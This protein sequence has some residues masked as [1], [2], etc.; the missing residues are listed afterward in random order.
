[1]VVP[2]VE[3]IVTD[4]VLGGPAVPVGL[5]EARRTQEQM[6]TLAMS[7]DVKTGTHQLRTEPTE[8]SPRFRGRRG[9]YPGDTSW[10]RL[11]TVSSSRHIVCQRCK[12]GI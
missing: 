4:K 3:A 12:K 11:G 7:R 10:H 6:I 5:I 9:S 2:V 1:M 8:G